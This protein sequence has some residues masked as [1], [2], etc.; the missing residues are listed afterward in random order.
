MNF[1]SLDADFVRLVIRF[2]PVRTDI[3]VCAVI[4]VIKHLTILVEEAGM[5]VRFVLRHL[6]KSAG[7]RYYASKQKTVLKLKPF[8]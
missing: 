4:L 2:G 5:P 7:D 3:F 1:V 6:Y 8:R